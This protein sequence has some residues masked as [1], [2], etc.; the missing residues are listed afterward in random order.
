MSIKTILFFISFTFFF[1]SCA[2]SGLKIQR[3]KDEKPAWVLNPSRLY[4]KN[5][6]I[7][8][9]GEGDTI[10]EARQKAIAS[11]SA[12]FKVHIKSSLD[13]SERA[14]LYSSMGQTRKENQKNISENI[15][16]TTNETLINVKTGESFTDKTGRIYTIAYLDRA[17]TYPIYKDRI[18]KNDA[19]ITYFINTAK[20]QSEI[21]K[22]Y[23]FLHAAFSIASYNETLIKQLQIIYRNATTSLNLSYNFNELRKIYSQT[24]SQMKFSVVVENDSDNKLKNILENALTSMNFSIANQG[25][26]NLKAKIKIEKSD[27]ENRYFNVRWFLTIKILYNNTIII[28]IEKNQR[29][30]GI[31]QTEAFSSSY[32]SIKNIIRKKMIKSIENYFDNFVKTYNK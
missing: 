13:L 19:N 3:T 14:S 23:A 2:S 30:S 24:A 6:Y 1:L 28:A 22:K 5:E 17:K 12:V 25:I 32:R 26:L 27:L 18:M 7:A 31:S 11:V 9:V 16:Q 29:E 20:N 21:V 15:K 4:P 10:D 8:A